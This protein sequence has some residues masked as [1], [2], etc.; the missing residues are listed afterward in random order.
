MY[1]NTIAERLKCLLYTAGFVQAMMLAGAAAFAV[2]TTAC[3]TSSQ[4]GLGPPPHATVHLAVDEA[5]ARSCID[6]LLGAGAIRGFWQLIHIR[7]F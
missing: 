7:I 4:F 6:Y 3:A 1:N 2:L 5:E